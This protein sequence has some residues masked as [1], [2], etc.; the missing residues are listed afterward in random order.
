[1]RLARAAAKFDQTVAVD[2]YTSSVTFKCQLAPLDLYRID[3]AAVKRRQMSCAP[4]V[5][6]PARK[7]VTIE[8]E[9][10]LIGD[11][12]PDHYNGTVI[13]QNFVLQGASEICSLNTIAAEL[14]GTVAGS[15]YGAL[16]F[17]KY[18][19]DGAD[20]SKYPP[21]YQ[22]FLAGS[23]SVSPDSLVEIDS[24]WFLI[25]DSY[26][27]LSGLRVALANEI[28]GTVFETVTVAARTYSPVTDS[29]TS[30]TSS[31]KVMRVRWQEHFTYMSKAQI[32]YFRGDETVFVLKSAMTPKGGDALMLSDGTWKILDVQDFGLTWSCHVRR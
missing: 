3:G 7:V 17:S 29:Y 19:P 18:L 8:G 10:Y 30:T 12:S 16:V 14:A 28:Q 13:R 15:A 27:S 25:K 22:I 26:I 6:I 4:G 11:G 1:M 31:K 5:V 21:Q 20:T 32:D 2:T 24:R 9:T 23:E